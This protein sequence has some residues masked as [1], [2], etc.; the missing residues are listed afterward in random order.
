MIGAHAS[1]ASRAPPL[2]PSSRIMKV[3]IAVE[4]R[5]WRTPDGCCWSETVHPRAYWSRYLSVFSGVTILAR[6][7]ETAAAQPTWRRVDGD[8]V[9]VKAIPAYVGPWEFVRNFAAVRTAIARATSDAS[10]ILLRVPGPIGSIARSAL[11][12]GRPYGLEVIADPYDVFAPGAVPH[13][14]RPLLRYGST[15]V[16]QRQ[17][18]TSPCILYVTQNALQRRYPPRGGVGSP[19]GFSI[20][21][22]DVELPESAFC[23]DSRLR[24]RTVH[25]AKAGRNG[26]F[27]IIFV[28]SL[29]VSYKA[30]QVLIT[31]FSR[32]VQS[33]LDADLTMVG[34]GRLRPRMESLAQ[35]LGV[36]D[37]V[38]FLGSIPAGDPVREQLD[39]SDLFVL[40]SRV[41]GLPRAMAEA[42]ARALPCIGTAVGGIP[43]L[44]PPEALVRPG[45]I[46][47]LAMKIRELAANPAQRA[48]WARRNLAK[49]REYHDEVLQPKRLSFYRYLRDLTLA[50]QLSEGV[51][52]LRNRA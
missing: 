42:M 6:V 35:S 45:D 51:Q 13:P 26:R 19:E 46:D 14:L 20:G 33:G 16:L 1:R 28:G 37:R 2:A 17:C 34:E 44:L 29:E 4:Q 24:A 47:E 32:C 9:S 15:K 10:A 30:P 7:H 8:V 11:S 3:T 38:R 49:A 52:G 21:V 18:R 41:E 31:A 12:R 43:E 25:Q 48:D 5:F 23:D 39:A 50:W 36:R 27:S 22:S 40:P